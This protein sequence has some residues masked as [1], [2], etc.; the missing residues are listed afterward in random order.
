MAVLDDSILALIA[1]F[2]VDDI[3]HL[4]ISD[5]KFLQQQ[6][7]EIK[8]QIGDVPDDQRQ[9]LVLA[10]I[11]EHAE[12]YREEW[13]RKSFS[14]L[15]L[16]QRC[17]DCPIIHNSHISHCMIHKKW[18]RLLHDYINGNLDSEKYINETLHL[19]DAHKNKLKISQISNQLNSK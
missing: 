16:S 8:N 9:R 19:L 4:S 5:E 17:S 15:P 6:V 10:W 12:R 3:D 18:T 13:K 7:A 2:V 11:Q 14:E 1:R